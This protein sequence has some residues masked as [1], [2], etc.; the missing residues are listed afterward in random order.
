MTL[1]VI[2][3]VFRKREGGGTLSFT[4]AL[5]EC[6]PKVLPFSGGQKWRGALVRPCACTSASPVVS[7]HLLAGGERERERATP[8]LIRHTSEVERTPEHLLTPFEF[9][10]HAK[11]NASGS[12]SGNERLGVPF[13]AGRTLND[14]E[15]LLSEFVDLADLKSVFTDLM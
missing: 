11:R 6:V 3:R 8:E 2:I 15:I 7:L 4:H 1:S 5:A 10:R 9:V 14:Y 13:K 12:T